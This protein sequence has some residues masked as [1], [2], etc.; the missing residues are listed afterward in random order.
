MLIYPF[1]ISFPV[2]SVTVRILYQL[3]Y[4]NLYTLFPYYYC[5]LPYYPLLTVISLII[6]C[7]YYLPLLY[8]LPFVTLNILYYT[9]LISI[10]QFPYR[11]LNP[12]LLVTRIPITY[13]I[14]LLVTIDI[15]NSLIICMYPCIPMLSLKTYYIST[16]SCLIEFILLLTIPLCISISLSVTYVSLN[17]ISIHLIHPLQDLSIP[18]L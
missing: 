4:H 1:L 14:T 10:L 8:Q 7:L 6:N 17:P 5:P 16:P 12:P 18:P 2:T 9:S 11:D 15:L 13:L 3:P